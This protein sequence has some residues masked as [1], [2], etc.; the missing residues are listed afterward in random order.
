VVENVGGF[1]ASA[2]SDDQVTLV[3]WLFGQQ[4]AVFTDQFAAL[5]CVVPVALLFTPPGAD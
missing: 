5:P 1:F 4:F 2:A 3:P